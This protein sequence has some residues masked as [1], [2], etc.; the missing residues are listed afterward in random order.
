MP[1]YKQ[2]SQKQLKDLFRLIYSKRASHEIC[3]DGSSISNL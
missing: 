1:M 2:M 3:K